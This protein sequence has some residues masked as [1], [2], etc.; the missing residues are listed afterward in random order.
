MVH[1][2]GRCVSEVYVLTLMCSAV[3]EPVGICDECILYVSSLEDCWFGFMCVF[4]VFI[5]GD[6]LPSGHVMFV[7]D[8]ALIIC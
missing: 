8:V 3:G 2:D 7:H 6:L 4:L 1:D 5:D